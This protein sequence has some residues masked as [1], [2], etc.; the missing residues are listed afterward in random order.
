MIVANIFDGI[1]ILRKDSSCYILMYSLKS[2]SYLR[3]TLPTTYDI[4]PKENRYMYKLFKNRISHT[5]ITSLSFLQNYIEKAQI[6]LDLD[7]ASLEECLENFPEFQWYDFDYYKS[8]AKML[9]S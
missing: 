1:Y 4:T 7:K 8:I 5:G 6:V 3:R 9:I 2:S